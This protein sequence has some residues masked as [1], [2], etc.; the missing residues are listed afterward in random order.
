MDMN[1]VEVSVD[2]DGE[3]AEAVSEVFNRF[4]RGGAVVETIFSNDD[5]YRYNAQL[6]VRVKTYLSPHDT[7]TRQKLEEALWFLSRLYPMPE[8]SFNTLK[9]EDWAH[10]W[11]KSYRPLRMGSHLMIVPSWW[12][13]TAGPGDLIIELDPGMAFGTGLHPTTRMC[14]E[15]L[16]RIAR[17]G[18]NVLDM[19]AGSGI[20][21][22]AAA[23]LGAASV[24]GVE[25]DPLAADVA[26][27]NVAR[28]A[29]SDVVR[30][31]TG[32][33]EV[34][35]GEF[36]LILINI[37]AEV[38]VSLVEEGLLRHIKPGGRFIA[39]GI[40]DERAAD[41]VSAIESHG[42]MIVE[43]RQEKDWVTLIGA[44]G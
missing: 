43:R 39:A 28:N 33:L 34:V 16:E 9:E 14:L 36:D 17:P 42:A 18:Q 32:S 40:V 1:W 44:V 8:P 5:T 7:E 15:A 25:K 29:V 35:H 37:L 13:F 2:V 21:S 19:G 4:G 38:I 27:E 24:L 22:I 3:A 6:L 26:R 10:A 23:R 41:V 11:K 20:L 12:D 31:E 30:V